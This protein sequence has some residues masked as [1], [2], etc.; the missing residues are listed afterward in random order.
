[1]ANL[2]IVVELFHSE[3][4]TYSQTLCGRR[5][6]RSLGFFLWRLWTKNFMSVH[7]TVVKLIQPGTK[8]CINQL[9][10]IATGAMPIAWLKILNISIRVQGVRAW[11]VIILLAQKISRWCSN[12][13]QILFDFILKIACYFRTS[14]YSCLFSRSLCSSFG[15]YSAEALRF[16]ALLLWSWWVV[17]GWQC[18]AKLLLRSGS[19]CAAVCT[20]ASLCLRF[21]SQRKE[22]SCQISTRSFRYWISKQCFSGLLKIV[23]LFHPEA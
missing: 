8:Q 10:N 4:Q 12:E 16:A 13:A 15:L 23:G 21:V 5:K 1:M 20:A 17:A 22:K 14:V 3:S 7:L 19:V 9:P 2:Q 18:E 6:E 11:N